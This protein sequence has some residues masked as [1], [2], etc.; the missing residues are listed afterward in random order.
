MRFS[1][2]IQSNFFCILHSRDHSVK[3]KNKEN[4]CTHFNID[5]RYLQPQPF[6]EI[7]ET[8]A[9]NVVVPVAVSNTL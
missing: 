2:E 7:I 1:L 9:K 6:S 4:Y 8:N 3:G 5:R